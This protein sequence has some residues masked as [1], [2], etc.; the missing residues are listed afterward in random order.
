MTAIEHQLR[1]RDG[2]T[3]QAFDVGGRSDPV[4]LYHH[5]TPGTGTVDPPAVADARERHLRL[6]S[7]DRPGYGRSTRQPGR[8]FADAAGDVEAIADQLDIDRFATYGHSGGGPHA[9]ATAALL[10]ERVAACISS[11]GP[12]P[13][14]ADGLD[15][16]AGAGDLN[17]EEIAVAA[18]G[19]DALHSYLEA[20]A[21]G[22]RSAPPA[23]MK[24]ELATLL[25]PVDREAFT[26]EVAVRF[27]RNLVYALEPGVDG[28]TDETLATYGPWGFELAEI[29]PPTQIWHGQ[30]DRFVPVSHAHWLAGHVTGAELHVLPDDGHV[31][32]IARHVGHMH[33]WLAEHL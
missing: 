25:A 13:F 27:H 5:G 19:F 20:Q 1:S 21:E 23:E 6:V 16:A 7:Y 9:L 4:V 8:S 28:Y 22:M 18:E 12:A 3:L 31:S 2:R 11:A 29:S 14:H 32:L 26:D 15:W 30:H 17:V 33:A 24:R 10:P